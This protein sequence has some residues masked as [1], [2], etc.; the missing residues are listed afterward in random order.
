MGGSFSIDNGTLT[1]TSE[2]D[3]DQSFHD[4]LDETT[5]ANTGLTQPTNYVP[6]SVQ[7]KR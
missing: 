5:E 6:G 3:S 4:T 7:K 1:Y 2:S